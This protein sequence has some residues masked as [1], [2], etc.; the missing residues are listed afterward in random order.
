[1]TA[2]HDAPASAAPW[3]PRVAPRLQPRHG[4]LLA[5]LLVAYAAAVLLVVPMGIGASWRECDTQAIARNLLVDGFDPLRPRIDWRGDTD[6]AV[7]AE[8]PL[9]QSLVATVMAVV[10]EAEW[11]GRLI[12]FL[13]MA[14][15]AVSLHRLCVARAGP[16]AALAATIAFLTGGHAFLLGARVTPDAMSVALAVAGAAAYLQYLA[17]G[18]GRTLWLSAVMVTLACLAKATA[19]QV[20][21]LLFLWTL[22]GAP[23]RLRSARPWI[24]FALIVGATAAWIWHGI[25]LHAETGL[26]FGVAAAG[27]TKFPTLR[28]LRNPDHW[29]SLL[30]TTASYGF[31]PFGLLAL[32]ALAL[33]RRLDRMDLALLVVVV[34]GLVGTLRY[35]FHSG[36]GPQYHAFA[37]VAG[38]WF[39]ARAWPS[40]ASAP[41]QALF[42][43]AALAHGCVHLAAERATRLDWLHSGFAE[44]GAAVAATCA[45][46]ELAVVHGHRN[47]I[48]DYWRRRTNFEEPM[49]LYH[50]R[51]RGWVLPRDGFTPEQLAALQSRGARV[52]V[53]Q[54]PDETPAAT[55]DWLQSNADLVTEQRGRRIY[56]LRSTS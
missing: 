7:E 21:L 20:G 12:S 56:R 4:L 48:D 38:S 55:H 51:R 36:V 28:S 40:R 17:T 24:A 25:R 31:G 47:R 44:A 13:A 50:A 29:W 6:G 5:G 26:T 9:Y 14:F 34:L 32:A 35:S 42:A 49:L 11:P 18:K 43:A 41:F 39:V 16:S 27:E 46:E 52:V 33:R 15:A 37:A 30:Q 19:L 23:A 22:V 10:G 8:F 54:L 1:M 2:H 3:F 45:P 53:D